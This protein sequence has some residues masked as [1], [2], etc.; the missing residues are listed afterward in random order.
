VK[1]LLVS[2]LYPPHARGGAER[3]ARRTALELHVRGHEVTVL[4]TMPYEGPRSWFA[5]MTE[6]NPETVYRFCPPNFYYLLD[7][8]RHPFALRALWHLVDTWSPHPARELK[9]LIARVQPD[10]VVTH[11]LK[12]LGLQAARAIRES[13]VPHA[14]VLHDVQLSV[15]S[16]LLIWGQEN[17]FLNGSFLRVWY[18]RRT[19]LAM[20]SPAVVVAPSR[21][22][23]EFHRA[24]GFFSKSRV[25]FLPNPAPKFPASTRRP[26]P[27]GTLRLFYAGQ[28][29]EHKG[30]RFLIDTLRGSAI[31]FTLHVAGDGSLSEEIARIAKED[32]RIVQHGF[33]SLDNLA[34]LLE[35][36]DATV[37]PS[38]CYEG[39]PAIIYE[40]LEGGVPVIASDI[41]GIAE[42][43]KDGGNGYLFTP[44]DRTAFAEK[45]KR[46]SEKQDASVWDAPSVR[47]TVEPYGIDRYVQSL[48]S[49]LSSV[50]KKD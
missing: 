23:M 21:F 34:K 49:I 22:L 39:S 24:R 14:H 10:V 50:A 15:P 42:L 1:I 8:H 46:L 36:V 19:Q 9:R 11:N 41:G 2:N 33:V 37:V 27:D 18:E 40:S 28:L 5:Q 20:G 44:G 7:D 13:G 17:D 38:L 3:I 12:G 32:P 30:V 6:R 26:S 25:E 48:E 29:E 45:L 35:T 4:S 31:P 47:S 16:G 43:V